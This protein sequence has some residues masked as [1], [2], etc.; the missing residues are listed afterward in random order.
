MVSDP[1]RLVASALEHRMHGLLWSAVERGDIDVPAGAE[2]TLASQFLRTRDHHRRL[3][4]ALERIGAVLAE[5][6]I[7][8]AT[9]KGVTAERRW[10]RR[11]GERPSRDLDL[12][13]A[14]HHLDRAGE[15]VR[16]LHPGHRLTDDVQALV[17]RRQL[18]SVDLVVDGVAVDLHFDPVKLG[19]WMPNLSSMWQRTVMLGRVRVMG[20]ADA[21]VQLLLHLAKD[22][23]SWLIGLADVPRL[24]VPP[25]DVGTVEAEA[26]EGGVER[27]VGASYATVQVLLSTG[28]T[29]RV[30]WAWR[31]TWP[32]RLFLD[33]DSGWRRARHRQVWI[34]LFGRFPTVANLR[35]LARVLFPPR[36]L[37][38]YWYPDES[39][40]Y[41][42]RLVRGR[43][44]RWVG[45]LMARRR[46]SHPAVAGVEPGEDAHR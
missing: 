10:Y 17:D 14:P 25:F 46:P 42:P 26:T 13:L 2:R 21:A 41:L 37:V 4:A 45:R 33:G 18:Q 3:W 8:V 11:M 9:F 40:S 31:L 22:R 32:R 30:P 19:V 44:R 28:D 24:F 15:V 29:A 38:A 34:P 39:G 6:G 20:E 43:V 12:W 5:R 23:F 36:P 7:E 35:A 27:P 1:D 16:L